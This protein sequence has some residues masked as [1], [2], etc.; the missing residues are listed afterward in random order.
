MKF[1]VFW[2][3][4]PCSL[5]VDRRFR[6]A[7]CL[8][9][10]DGGITNLWNLGLLWDY[11]ALHPRRFSSCLSL[12]V[13]YLF[14]LQPTLFTKPDACKIRSGSRLWLVW[15]ILSRQGSN[16]TV[17]SVEDRVKSY[18]KKLRFWEKCLESNQTMFRDFTISWRRMNFRW[19]RASKFKWLN[20][21]GGLGRTFRERFSYVTRN[22]FD[23][24]SV[25]V[26]N[27]FSSEHKE[28]LI[29]LFIYL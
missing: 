28:Q 5:G 26:W 23:D 15:Q 12:S 9:R 25:F 8:H 13:K 27:T 20:T 24:T 3:V 21:W 17:F 6:G 7:Y 4:A 16:T 14:F 19:M 29:H 1:S 18:T 10:P 2:D 22:P 11:T